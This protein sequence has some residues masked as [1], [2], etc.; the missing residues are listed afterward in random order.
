MVELAVEFC[1]G[2]EVLP[3]GW[4]EKFCW[5]VA[6]LVK[7]SGREIGDG[8]IP[9]SLYLICRQNDWRLV[10]VRELVILSGRRF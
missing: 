7:R 4:G 10:F 6:N 3:C 1:N 8:K 2:H 5:L 9:R